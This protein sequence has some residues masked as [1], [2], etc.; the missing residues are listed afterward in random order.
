MLRTQVNQCSFG[1]NYKFASLKLKQ[2]HINTFETCLVNY[3]QQISSKFLIH[4]MQVLSV[5]FRHVTT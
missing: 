2:V 3:K 1:M 4:T 5:G